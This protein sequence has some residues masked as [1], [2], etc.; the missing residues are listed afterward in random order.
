MSLSIDIDDIPE[1]GPLE[2]DLSESADQFAVYSEENSLAEP[3]R[4]TGSLTRSNHDIFWVGEVSTVMNMTCSRC[5]EPFR[6]DVHTPVTTS[7]LPAPDADELEA[8]QELVESDIELEYYT[9]H[10]IDLTQ[11][12]YDQIML[13]LP[14][15]HLCTEDCK[16]ICPQ[17][18]ASLNREGCRC[19]GDENIDPRL[20]VLKQLKDKLK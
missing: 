5:L 8:E 1:D 9:D 15:V 17:C 12:V 7:F 13:S 10:K 16:G 14:M 2:L 20:A 19:E 6:L 3:V 18:G 4:V 11:S